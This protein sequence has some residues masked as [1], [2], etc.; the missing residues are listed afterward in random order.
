MNLLG[1][2][3]FVGT[4]LTSPS[5]SGNHST[6]L[7]DNAIYVTNYGEIIYEDSTPNLYRFIDYS[8]RVDLVSFK[9]QFTNYLGTLEPTFNLQVYESD[10]SNGPWMPSEFS[11]N[12]G[13][14]FLT[15]CKRYIKLELTIFFENPEAISDFGLLLFL[16]V[17]IHD[18][19]IPTI[20]DSARSI[21]SNFPSWTSLYED[22]L[23]RA[24][25]ELATPISVGG[26]FLNSLIGEHLENINS[27]LS[28]Q[29][30]DAF[31]STANEDSVDWIYVSY[32]AP[33][34]AIK[35]SGD[36]I[37]LSRTGSINELYGYKKTDYAYYHDI[38]DN[39]IITLRKFQILDI[40]GIA[41]SQQPI[42][43]FNEF[44]EFGAKVGLGR[45]FLENNVNYKKRIL[46]VYN[47]IPSTDVEGLK[48]TLRR[49]LDIWRAY[50]ATP[51]SNYLGATPEILEISEIES[52]TPY[53]K[54]SRVPE[55]K[56]FEFGKSINEKYPFTYGY[57]NWEDGIWDVAGINHEG[58]TTI[59]SVYDSERATQN[60]FQTGVGDLE[61]LMVFVENDSYSTVSF[62]GYFQASGYKA[63]SFTDVYSPIKIPIVYFGQY[64]HPNV[65]DPDANN[66]NKL[67][68]S[69]NGGVNLVYEIDLKAHDQYATPSV[70]FKNFS[71]L[72]REDFI[73]K[74]YYSQNSPSSPEYNL[75]K[76]F[77]SD[78]FSNPSIDFVEKTYGYS[79]ANTSATPVTNSINIKDINNIRLVAQ[80]KWNQ[81][82]QQYQNVT[83]AN[84]R[85]AFNEHSSGYQVNPSF[86]AQH[87]L[88]TPNINYIN[89]NFKIGSTVYGTQ[90][91]YGITDQISDEIE[92]NKDNDI[93]SIDN[94]KIL[95]DDLKESLVYPIG[96]VPQN[97]ILENEKSQ[98]SPLYKTFQTQEIKDPEHGG[99]SENP[100]DINSPEYFIPSSPN[101]LI[102]RYDTPDASGLPSDTDYFESATISYS[103]PT[104]SVVITTGLSAT[105]Y[106][107]FKK[108]I[109]SNIE[110][111][112]IKSTPMIFGYLDMFGNA[113]KQTEKFEDLGRSPNS[114]H[115][116][117]FVGKY[118]VNRNSFGIPFEKADEYIISE[119]N[120]ISLN[121][122]IVLSTSK[123][124][125]KSSGY[126]PSEM[127]D[128]I[129]EEYDPH[130]GNYKYSSIMV[131]AKN[132]STYD[133]NSLNIFDNKD[134]SL[135]TGWLYLSENEY[136]VYAK[137]IVDIYN[138]QLFE[139]DLSHIPTQAA[140]ILVNSY[141]NG[142]TI[143]YKEAYFNDASTPGN[144]TFR[145]QE[146]INGS[147]DLAL[148]LAYPIVSNIGIQD[149]FTG[150][151]LTTS[152]LNPEFYIWTFVD[153]NGNHVVDTEDTG[154][155]YISSSS[156]IQSG[157]SFYS[158][159]GN[160]LQIL[161]SV[162]H[163]SVVVPGREYIVDYNVD[164]AFYVERN[165]KKLYLSSTPS[166]SSIYNVVY[167]SSEFLSST[168]SGLSINTINNPIDEGYIFVSDSE[169]DFDSASVWV[170]PYKISNSENDFVYVSIIS[171]DV[172]GNPKPNQTFRIYGTYMQADEEYLT[173]NNNGF[174]K[175][176]VKYTGGN[177][178]VSLNLNIQGV[179]YPSFG[180]NKNSQSSGFLEQCVINLTKNETSQFKLR[181]AVDNLNIKANL[182]DSVYIS[183]YVRN[184]NTPPSSTPIIYW[185][186]ARTAYDALNEIEYAQNQSVPGRDGYSGY[187][188]ADKYGNFNIGP[189]D[190]Q[191]RTNPGLWFVVVET[192]MSSTPSSE[193]VT[194]YGD[195]VYWFENYDNIHYSN[196]L[197]PLPRFYTAVPL[198]GDEIIKEPRFKYEYVNH[199]Y[200]ASPS[201]TPE[202]NWTP[203]KWF[204][205]S[206][207]EQYQMGLF[208][209]TPNV[210]SSYGNM[211]EDYEDS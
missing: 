102:K 203:P 57:V 15:N 115:V 73:V 181:A 101:I 9:A 191:D 96:V 141:S 201:A 59:P 31:I 58:I 131:D 63:L 47:N 162:T 182:I 170:S 165:E 110:G 6:P 18:I 180:A 209:S 49:E 97:L 199:E 20:S 125:V 93:S 158:H 210:I 72:D 188:K 2:F 45:L 204:P 38:I 105:P 135:K 27:A 198:S 78:G 166:D 95:I 150:K 88:S 185:R 24:T 100:Y 190:S 39:Q 184:N 4:E 194:I 19:S 21:L 44:D 67:N 8:S 84:Y 34:A 89:A 48:R 174:A 119:I 107:P 116:D 13:V 56:L 137:P 144:V 37:A 28:L 128:F 36:S 70:F 30:L 171:Y 17:L 43:L 152:L 1:D 75:I 168:P 147:K 103:D 139:I 79:Y 54:F 157:D 167:E 94:H 32:A 40:D 155:Y 12:S 161:D 177:S 146:I 41:Y 140:P 183:G 23:E 87:S 192:E 114:N 123:S 61:D 138:G 86:G 113:Y 53:I 173:T 11:N 10:T 60:Y 130:I 42:L 196:E 151:I 148:Y 129:Y 124:A 26:K 200:D 5:Y 83:N 104:K 121:E 134:P 64:Y 195:V 126:S 178:G 50:G 29:S 143:N 77:N 118:D 156:A 25:P 187:V 197:V 176:T 92:I 3:V 120:P 90:N 69:S 68:P 112:E 159:I 175:T 65:P 85:V 211:Y 189:F 33:N 80:A 7:D 208:G 169:Y 66:P 91:V 46:D 55:D 154:I 193:P 160:R 127:I 207:Y 106:Y 205:I 136:Y 109:W 133:N 132:A 74:N 35:V 202:L 179:S 82:T 22:S 164:E 99:R 108:P 145:N 16:D 98:P 122:D 149:S 51:D 111:V 142:S 52:S 206:R 81:Q 153:I 71:Y 14:I 62:E 186:K 76:V 117:S 163:Q 172:L